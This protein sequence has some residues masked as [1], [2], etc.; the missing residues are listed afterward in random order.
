M[1]QWMGSFQEAVLVIK[2]AGYQNINL[3]LI[4]EMSWLDHLVYQEWKVNYPISLCHV[5]NF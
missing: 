3:H 5:Q 4:T 2:S 1:N